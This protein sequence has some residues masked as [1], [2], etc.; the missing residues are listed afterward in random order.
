MEKPKIKATVVL[1]IDNEGSV[2][3]AQ[4]KQAIHHEDGSID[5]SLGTY[6]GYGGKMEDIDSDIFDTA[7]RELQ[8]ESGVSASKEDLEIVSRVYFYIKKE[9]ESFEPFMDVSFFFLNS[10][11]GM[12]VEG[13]EMGVPTFFSTEDIPYDEMMPAD[14]IFFKEMFDGKRNVYEV[15]LLG[16]KVAPEIVVL[17]EII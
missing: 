6:N 3:L 9:D 11:N 15:K 1:M 4:K 10:W 16:K 12:P 17:D 7:I 13:R 8:D 2:C 5:Y 14:R